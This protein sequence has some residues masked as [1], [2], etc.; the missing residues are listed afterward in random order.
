MKMHLFPFSKHNP[1]PRLENLISFAWTLEQYARTLYWVTLMA[2][3]AC[4]K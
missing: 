3:L 4:A 1:S 2:F